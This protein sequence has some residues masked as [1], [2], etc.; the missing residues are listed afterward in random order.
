MM[1]Q[2]SGFG[3]ENPTQQ[4]AH[5]IAH[6][7]AAV[8]RRALARAITLVES[9]RSDHRQHAD[10]L[11]QAIMPLTGGSLRL[12]LSGP[13]GVGKSTLIEALGQHW[14]NMGLRVAVLAV[15]PS[16]NLTGGALL[17]DKTRMEVLSA[18]ELAF[19]RPS[20]SGGHL[21]GVAAA[22][23]EALLLCE[24]A[25]FQ[26]VMVETVGVGQSEAAV[27]DMTDAFVLVQQAHTGDE[28]QTLK[29]GV[30][31]R[32]DAVLVNKTDLDAAAAHLAME[33]AA[34]ALRERLPLPQAD[35]RLW[36]AGSEPVPVWCV[37][38]L[39]GEGL[40]VFAQ[41]LAQAHSQAREQGRL[42]RL[43]QA[44]EQAFLEE[45]LAAGWQALLRSHRAYAW[46]VSQG[47]QTLQQGGQAASVLARQCLNQLLV[48]EFLP[49]SAPAL[50]L[51]H[52]NLRTPGPM[53]QALRAF[54]AEV[55]GLQEGPRPP[56]G[57]KGYWMYAS[58]HPVLHL[59]LSKPEPA[60]ES[61][62]P[63]AGQGQ[64]KAPQG[65]LDHV[66][67]RMRDYHGVSERLKRLGVHYAQADVPQSQ[68]R[69][70]FIRDP[71]GNT[72]ELQFDLQEISC[73]TSSPS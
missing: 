24:A 15:D 64:A 55:V 50:A 16:S 73:T 44:Q 45:S 57:T 53:Q 60:S 1:Q 71:A 47:T 33:Q 48:Q 27:A 17:A 29:K 52:V 51:D 9:T 3:A 66:A 63:P 42:Q 8:R 68:Q 40:S 31:E 69:Q 37:S 28:L 49:A 62:M 39:T 32:A 13:P 65:S 72:V 11:L 30:M 12:G 5:D 21:G 10:A 34:R 41:A 36:P 35:D 58:G 19:V 20:P 2:A 67:F 54:Y 70:L 26:V 56:F 22:S 46:V 6:A 25:G 23:R 7:N 61:S 18:H 43:R 59:S 14:L 38:A 4:L